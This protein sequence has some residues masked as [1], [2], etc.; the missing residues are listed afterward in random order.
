MREARGDGEEEGRGEGEK[1][2]GGARESESPV[3]AQS[4][5]TSIEFTQFKMWFGN[6]YQS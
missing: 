5:H 1:E 2:R 6:R 3:R 4:A